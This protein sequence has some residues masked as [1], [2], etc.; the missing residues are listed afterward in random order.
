MKC[1]YIAP[2]AIVFVV[3]A[4]ET[5]LVSSEQKKRFSGEDVVEDDEV[6]PW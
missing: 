6:D 3:R 5:I 4:R 1:K 2:E